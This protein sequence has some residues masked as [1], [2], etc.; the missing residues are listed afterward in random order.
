MISYSFTT[1]DLLRTR[2]AI[3]PLLEA[4]A[5][6]SALRDPGNR[7]SIHLPWVRVAR[8]AVKDLDLTELELLTV[9]GS[10]VP[11]FLSPPPETPLPDV[12]AELARV[13]RTPPEQVR[14]ELGWRFGSRP[15]AAQEKLLSDPRA[16]A[17]RLA[18]A[19]TAYWAA[20]IAPHWER[21]RACLENDIRHRTAALTARG[22][23][24]VFE[25][26][27]PQVSWNDDALV[28]DRE[29]DA[30]VN[31]KRR[32]L[33]L[34]PS[35]FIWPNVSGMIDP[36]WQPALIYP[37]RGIGLLWEPSEADPT[38]LYAVLGKGRARVLGALDGEASTT[39]VARRLSASPGGVSEHL[40][41]LR[42]AGL[43]RPRR[44]G[45][46]VLYSRTA[47]GDALMRAPSAAL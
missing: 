37:P 7:G 15:T 45:R 46:E 25:A 31:L 20:A 29:I 5:S 28:L 33:Q 30:H 21:I 1:D 32:G 11:D 17:R 34:V 4:T 23:I 24:G 42:R 40:S 6:L 39:E 19:M 26:L 14:A 38:A 41:A 16:A 36:P 35:V 2:F 13:A 22:A 44:A 9:G 27:H 3:S 47:A 43:V 18:E 10:Y 12:E 8:E